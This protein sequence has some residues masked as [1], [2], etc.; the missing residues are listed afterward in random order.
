M[1]KALRYI[2]LGIPAGILIVLG[3]IPGLTYL[4]MLGLGLIGKGNI[5]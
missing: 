4:R 1:K 3:L 2:L 5:G